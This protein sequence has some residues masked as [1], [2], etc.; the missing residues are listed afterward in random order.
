MI[1]IGLIPL[2]DSPIKTT[3]CQPI[4]QRSPNAK[5]PAGKTGGAFLL[6]PDQA[7]RLFWARSWL[8]KRN[9]HSTTATP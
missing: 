8:A 2:Q 4:K 6:L 9:I 1:V 7:A 3:S 5:S